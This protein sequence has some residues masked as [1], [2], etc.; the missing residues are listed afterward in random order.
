M[1]YGKLRPVWGCTEFGDRTLSG[2]GIGEKMG[3]VEEIVRLEGLAAAAGKGV[4][5]E[6]WRAAKLIWEELQVKS[7][8]D[9]SEEIKL[10]GGKGSIGHLQRAKRCWQL[11]IDQGTDGAAPENLP[12]F[13]QIYQ[14][15]VARPE[16]AKP[17]VHHLPD[18][19]P[20]DEP[21]PRRRPGHRRARDD[22][23]DEPRGPRPGSASG[24]IA[25]ADQAIST[26]LEHRAFVQTMKDSDMKLLDAIVVK[27]NLLAEDYAKSH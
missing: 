24:L 3:N 2:Y 8:R 16:K 22:E 20:D 21:E 15:E 6:R 4:S 1:G 9:L 25:Q 13:G 27:I 11:M 10:A 26:L 19:E 17:P 12:D 18:P 5:A 7:F 23:D 14:S